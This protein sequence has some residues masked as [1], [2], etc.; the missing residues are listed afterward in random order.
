MKYRPQFLLKP[1]EDLLQARRWVTELAHWYNDEH[2]HSAINFVTPAQRHAGDGR[3][4]LQARSQVY[5]PARQE[6]PR[7][8]SKNTRDWSFVEAVHLNLE[9][10]EKSEAEPDQKAT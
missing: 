3:A 1:F 7:R 4:M 8:G 10:P 5:E 9:T 2:R 6:N